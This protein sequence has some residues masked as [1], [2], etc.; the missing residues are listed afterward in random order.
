MSPVSA[1]RKSD[2][3]RMFERDWRCGRGIGLKDKG[4]GEGEDEDEGKENQPRA[5][6]Q[7]LVLY[8]Q[9]QILRSELGVFGR[10]PT[11]GFKL[12]RCG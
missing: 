4:E 6:Q 3:R 12:Y 7:L 1:I 11:H 2:V 10:K 8:A 5:A 9:C